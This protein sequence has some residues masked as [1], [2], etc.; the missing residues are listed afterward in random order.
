MGKPPHTSPPRGPCFRCHEGDMTSEKMDLKALAP[1]DCGEDGSPGST[2]TGVTVASL[3]K[4][5]SALWG[6]LTSQDNYYY[7]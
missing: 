4:E 3:R 2:K 6:F 1:L 7:D 5:R